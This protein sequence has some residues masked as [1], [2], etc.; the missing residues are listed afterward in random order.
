MVTVL[1]GSSLSTGDAWLLMSISSSASLLVSFNGNFT[2][3]S[4]TVGCL[5]RP[6][7]ARTTLTHSSLAV[8]MLTVQPLSFFLLAKANRLI[9]SWIINVLFVSKTCKTNAS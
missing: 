9:A 5:T 6:V 7:T 2:F 4:I 3:P 1:S 8:L